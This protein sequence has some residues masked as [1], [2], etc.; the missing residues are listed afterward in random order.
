M[1]ERNRVSNRYGLANRWALKGAQVAV[2]FAILAWA[3]GCAGLRTER[4]YGKVRIQNPFRLSTLALYPVNR[5]CDVLDIPVAGVQ[6]GPGLNLRFHL[7]NLF[8]ICLPT[9][10]CGPEVG[11]N[12]HWIDPIQNKDR[13]YF[14]KRYRPVSMGCHGGD[15]LPFPIFKINLG[16]TK[17][18]PDAIEVGAHALAAGGRAGIR[19]LEVV[20]LVTGFVLLDLNGDDIYV[21]AKK[22]ADKEQEEDEEE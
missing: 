13:N 19:P 8:D 2:L 9:N 4:D 7:T 21:K 20:D 6:A 12:T 14:W 1:L 17:S 22:K 15:A 16:E 5:V 10:S 18:S 3:A 11:W